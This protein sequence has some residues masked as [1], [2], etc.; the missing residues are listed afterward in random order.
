M[1]EHGDV[2]RSNEVVL[3]MG[4]VGRRRD[5]N[6][7]H[8]GHL[9]STTLLFASACAV[10]GTDE[11]SLSKERSGTSRQREGYWLLVL[12]LIQGGLT[13]TGLCNGWQMR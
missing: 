11:G 6:V 13:S 9:G 4:R 3:G 7:S 10:R 8:P 5:G 12:G 2:A 1:A